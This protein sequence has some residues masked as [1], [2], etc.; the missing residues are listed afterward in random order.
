MEFLSAFH[1]HG[2]IMKNELVTKIIQFIYKYKDLIF[3]DFVCRV[4]IFNNRYLTL[5][6]E[7]IFQTPCWKKNKMLEH[8]IWIH[9][10]L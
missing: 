3:V 2:L 4:Y 5:E 9:M 6:Q 7:N 8:Q 1:K 10:Y